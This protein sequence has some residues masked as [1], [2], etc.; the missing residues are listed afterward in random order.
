MGNRNGG[1]PGKLAEV[2][3]VNAEEKFEVVAEYEG[4]LG[5]AA[6]DTFTPHGFV[7]GIVCDGSVCLSV[8]LD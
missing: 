3:W 4:G 6:D 1:A 5:G 2:E 8:E 7:S